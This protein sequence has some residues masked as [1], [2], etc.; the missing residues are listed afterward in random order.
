MKIDWRLFLYRCK[1]LQTAWKTYKIEFTTGLITPEAN[2]TQYI[3]VLNR[4]WVLDEVE[5][6]PHTSL[7]KYCNEDNNLTGSEYNTLGGICP[8]KR[9]GYLFDKPLS[10]NEDEI[11]VMCFIIWLL[12]WFRYLKGYRIY[13]SVIFV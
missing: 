12:A 8:G 2:R 11:K 6:G 9:F 13:F 10:G 3:F 4:N 7:C 1:S 5:I